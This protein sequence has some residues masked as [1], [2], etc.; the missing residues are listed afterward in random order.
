MN[1]KQWLIKQFGN[2]EPVEEVPTEPKAPDISPPSQELA[3][4]IENGKIKLHTVSEGHYRTYLKHLGLDTEFFYDNFNGKL[5]TISY[6]FTE[7]E[8]KL[9]GQA[10]RTYSAKEALAKKAETRNEI[11]EYLNKTKDS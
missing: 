2:K 1:L 7:D 4:A 11:T 5:N 8:T 6:A 9:L 3:E 10:L